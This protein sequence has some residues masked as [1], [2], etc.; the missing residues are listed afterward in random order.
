MTR[1]EKW[2]RIQIRNNLPEHPPGRCG[3]ISSAGACSAWG[4]YWRPIGKAGFGSRACSV[5][6]RGES[7]ATK[8]D[9]CVDIVFMIR[10]ARID[11]AESRLKR[12]DLMEIAE[13]LRSKLR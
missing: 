9:I 10:K 7:N 6:A 12:A 11:R 4:R 2:L 8:K 5:H 1:E 3:V 13:L